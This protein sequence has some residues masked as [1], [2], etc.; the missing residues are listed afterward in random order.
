MSGRIGSGT[1]RWL[2]GHVRRQGRRLGVGAAAMAL[3]AGVLL[4]LPWPLKYIVDSV[5]YGKPL[6]AWAAPW[7]PDPI[8]HR[9]LL[10]NGLGAAILLLGCVEAVL[11]YLGNR[12]LLDAAQRIGVSVGRD[13]FAH[14]LRLPL[15]FHRRHLSGELMAR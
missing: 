15:A 1:W 4:L 2:G 6:G 8:A 11:A 12:L 13:F 3:R 10:L 9:L 14:L 7:L 5:I